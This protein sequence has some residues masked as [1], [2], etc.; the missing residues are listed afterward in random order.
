MVST[1][2]LCKKL[3]NVKSAVIEGANFYTDEDGVN[4]IRI[5]ARPN[6]WHEDD[7]PFCH[8]RC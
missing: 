1:N 6:V 7:C 8:K 5:H 3:L 4:H 2:T